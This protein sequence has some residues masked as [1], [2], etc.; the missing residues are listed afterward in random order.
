MSETTNARTASDRVSFLRTLRAVRSFRSDPVPQE[1]VDDVLQVARWSGSASNKQPWEILVVR[2]R[3]TLRS[4]ASLGGYAGH[5]AGA[6]L[7]IVLVMA[8]ER[9]EQ[10]TYDEGRLA[11]R[12]MLAAHAHGVG[13]SI[14]W[15]VGSGRDA[16]KELLGIPQEK[17]VR[18]A[19]SLGYPHDESR[20]SRAGR[21]Q[22]RKPLGEII[23]QERYA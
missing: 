20:R 14:G 3:D 15:L 2:E 7:G 12:I 16:A 5:L 8:G 21:G 13:S 4:L 1:V 9:A 10:E 6:P 11:E 19:I 18:T 22:A 23:Y 17:V